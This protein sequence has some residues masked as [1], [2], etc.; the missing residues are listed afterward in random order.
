MSE[1]SKKTPEKKSFEWTPETI[2]AVLESLA[3]FADKF[4]LFKNQES[5]QDNRFVEST[6]KHDRRVITIL[7][8]FL[9]SVIMG[10]IWLTWVG[11]VSG[12]ALLFAVGL[13]IGYVFAL[14]TRF[15]FGSQRSVSENPE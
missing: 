11:K 12:D 15:I 2:R 13:I 9:G 14:I 8:I 6:S 5:T 1:E 10:M 7:L 3:P 4:L